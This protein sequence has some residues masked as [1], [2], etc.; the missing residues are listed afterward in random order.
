MSESIELTAR[1]AALWPRMLER[2]LENVGPGM[3]ICPIYST[4]T[5]RLRVLVA[6]F[7]GG[8]A[9]GEQC[10]Y[11]ADPDRADEVAQALHAL[12]PPA[13]TEVDRGALVLV[14]TREL[15]VRNGEFDP[16]AMF[17]L[18]ATAD[19]RAR[20]SGYSALRIAGEMSWV[21]GADMGNRPFLELEALLNETLPGPQWLGGLPLRP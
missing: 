13:S 12:G 5:D 18:H 20:S 1:G 8:L 2:Q 16:Q 10:L 4:P 6:F 21:L 9:H 11:F 3:H 14:T 17:Q 19:E 7:G 15:Y